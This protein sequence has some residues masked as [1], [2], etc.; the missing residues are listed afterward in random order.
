MFSSD[1]NENE[2]T[3]FP[4]RINL[5]AG[6]CPESLTLEVMNVESPSQQRAEHE[7]SSPAITVTSASVA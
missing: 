1:H 2:Q 5:S 3:V 4:S 7:H 6:S